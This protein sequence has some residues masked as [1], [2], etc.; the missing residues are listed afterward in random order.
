MLEEKIAVT[1]A[2]P[3][4][5]REA[6]SIRMMVDY[7]LHDSKRI[8]GSERGWGSDGSVEVLPWAA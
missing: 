3:R 2:F 6:E 7:G 1:T 8:V 5:L 4:L